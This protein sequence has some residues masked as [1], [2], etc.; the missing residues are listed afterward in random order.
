MNH[1]T[2]YKEI[3]IA[4]KQIKKALPH[5]NP[6]CPKYQTARAIYAD[7]LEKLYNKRLAIVDDFKK[8]KKIK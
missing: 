3:A 1:I 4:I 8:E 7:L 5:G 6:N 2:E